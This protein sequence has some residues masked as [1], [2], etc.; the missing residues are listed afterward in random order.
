MKELSSLNHSKPQKLPAERIQILVDRVLSDFNTSEFKRPINE[1]EIEHFENGYYLHSSQYFFAKKYFQSSDRCDN[2]S[3]LLADKIIELGLT[4]LTLIGFRSYTGLLLSKTQALLSLSDNKV[5]Y[6]IIEQKKEHEFTWQ[7]IPDFSKINSNFL[8]ILPITCTCSTYIRIRKYLRRQI[9]IL[10]ENYK[11]GD[12]QKKMNW[13]VEDNF[14]NVFLIQEEDIKDAPKPIIVNSIT[15][16]KLAEKEDRIINQTELKLSK[17]YS[18]YNW[19][20]IEEDA[21]YFKISNHNSRNYIG[22]PLIKLYSKLYLPEDCPLC[23]PGEGKLIAERNIFPTHNNFETPNL[24]FGFPTFGEET[25]FGNQ[26]KIKADSIESPNKLLFNNLFAFNNLLG[27]SHLY[28]HINVNGSSYLHYVRGNAFYLQNKQHILNFFNIEFERILLNTTPQKKISDIIFITSESKHNSTF[29]EEI[30]TDRILSLK[31][32]DG[33]SRFKVHILRFD[34]SN[35]FIDNFMSNYK[36]ILSNES[37]I[38]IYFEEVISA[39][40][41]FKLISNYLKHY[42]LKKSNKKENSEIRIHGFD[43]IFSIID[44]TPFYTREELIK[45]LYSSINIYPELTFISFFKLNVPI[46]EVAHLGNPL[47][48]NVVHL[49]NMLAESHLDSLKE[50][51]GIELPLRIPVQLPEEDI[52]INRNVTLSYFPFEYPNEVI[53]TELF[54]I[55]GDVLLNGKLDLLKL[56]ISHEINTIL[57]V[58]YKSVSQYKGIEKEQIKYDLIKYINEEIWFKMHDKKE[59]FFTSEFGMKGRVI[60]AEREIVHDTIIKILSR[61]P[62]TYYKDVYDSIFKYCLEQMEALREGIGKCNGKISFPQLRKYKFYTRRLVD[63]DSSYLISHDFIYLMKILFESDDVS[64]RNNILD[65]KILI[66]ETIEKQMP[67][68]ITD[69]ESL[70]T[71]RL[72]NLFYK[73]KQVTS[74]FIFL[75]YSC[76][77]SVFKNHY[78]SIKLE[79][80][81]NSD[82]LL[83]KQF[84]TLDN[85]VDSTLYLLRDVYYQLTGMIKA[86]NIYLLSE[87][88]NLHKRNFLK[89]LKA[90]EYLEIQKSE[91]NQIELEKLIRKLKGDWP[92][93]N[94]ETI[95]KYYFKYK[96][97][98]PIILNANKFIGRSRFADINRYPDLQYHEHIKL[99]IAEMLQSATM[100]MPESLLAE[101]HARNENIANDQSADFIQELRHVVKSVVK[102]L[103]HG[104]ESTHIE[105]GSVESK[106]KYALCFEYMDRSD[107]ETEA[108]NIFV[109]SSDETDTGAHLDKQGLI[110]NLLYGL[111]SFDKSKN[112]FPKYSNDELQSLL[113]TIRK[114]DSY[115]SFSDDYIT[116]KEDVLSFNDMFKRDCNKHFNVKTGLSV[117]NDASLCLFFRLS[118]LDEK[119]ISN[120]HFLLKGKAVLVVTNNEVPTTS[121][122]LNFMSNEKVRLLLLLKE[123]LL[124]FIQSKIASEVIP[125]SLRE[126]IEAETKEVMGHML[127]GYWTAMEY[128]LE[129]PVL[130]SQE[131]KI[132]EFIKT[133]IQAHLGSKVK[134]KHYDS[135]DYPTYVRSD[136]EYAFTTLMQLPKLS[137]FNYTLNHEYILDIKVNNLKCHHLIFEQVFS[138]LIINMR[139]ATDNLT[140]LMTTKQVLK[141]FWEDNYIVFENRFAPN[142]IVNSLDEKKNGGKTMCHDILKELGLSMKPYIVK[143]IFYQVKILINK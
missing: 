72:N 37:S 63:L 66:E 21:V 122:Y 24:L 106:L 123:E 115:F 142:P 94:A 25:R 67:I 36:N 57:S 3:K 120:E 103:Q 117:L 27:N 75:I 109:L 49:K 48:D 6:A 65:L 138:E 30:A 70:L 90:M 93:E 62:F 114:N 69:E 104:I 73:H 85:S 76:K 80:L 9:E 33:I 28:G 2:L 121:N 44:R 141:V 116:L 107:I 133:R 95:A 46:V 136:F 8:I 26:I 129:L 98:D 101:T 10:N 74:F 124:Q 64:H 89:Y 58:S 47:K 39:G 42:K 50:K 96:K 97:N 92:F 23:F 82:R 112:A 84:S 29:L 140:N 20:R 127:D 32:S 19:D 110:Y 45:K 100:L 41:T 22:H 132:V 40:R 31:S 135:S 34:S 15:L 88:K 91:L 17:L 4:N 126:R 81:I 78:R 60:E 12:F 105:P 55:Y 13:K 43:Y 1:D 18:G 5:D 71:I 108:D 130:N 131:I 125:K 143:E 102:I 99:A 52:V 51:I 119:I 35:E 128:Y 83:P 87:L 118:E 68:K 38:I 56:Y 79:E 54:N 7:F 59:N 61:H 137:N 11:D 134:I 16:S 86:E 139:R 113:I 14:I 111:K 53:S 77:E